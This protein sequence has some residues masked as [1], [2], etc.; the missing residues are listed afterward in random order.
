MP[1]AMLQVSDLVVA[2]SGLPVL[3]SLGLMA[4][5][6]RDPVF[7]EIL[8]DVFRRVQDGSELSAAFSQHGEALPQLFPATLKAGERS[9]EL[10]AVVLRFVRYMKLVTEAR[11]KVVSALVYPAA[12][13]GLSFLLIAVM[14]IYVVPKFTEF[15]SALNTELP[16]LTRITLA[17]SRFMTRNNRYK[18]DMG[19]HF[20]DP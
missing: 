5:R 19:C 8:V 16:L 11:R 18:E 20:K 2:Y 14:S 13:V 6:Q 17:F 3:Q 9:G 12:L 1:E 10:E 15:F 7:K 4:D